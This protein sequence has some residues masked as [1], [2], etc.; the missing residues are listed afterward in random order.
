M[1]VTAREEAASAVPLPLPAQRQC[2]SPGPSTPDAAAEPGSSAQAAQGLSGSTAR[3]AA[4]FAVPTAK[5][6][7]GCPDAPLLLVLGP[8]APASPSQ[9]Q[10]ASASSVSP[11]APTAA[12]AASGRDSPGL[13]VPSTSES[14]AEGGAGQGSRSEPPAL[15]LPRRV[16]ANDPAVRLRVE[17]GLFSGEALVLVQ[18]LASTPRGL[19]QGRS[20]RSWVALQG[21]FKAPVR[22]DSLVTGQ[23][24][25]RPFRR[26]PPAWMVE[27][28]LLGLARKISGGAVM[29]GP[30]SAPSVLMPAMA[31][32]SIIN[33]SRPGSQPPLLEAQEDVRLFAPHLAVAPP[34]GSPGPSRPADAPA[35]KR[36]FSAARHREGL[37]YDT[38]HVWTFHF[39]QQFVDLSAY[40]L[41]FGCATYDL[42]RHLDG[43]PLQFM[44]KDVDSGSYL[45]QVLAWHQRLLTEAAAAAAGAAG[46]AEAGAG[47]GAVVGP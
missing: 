24:F 39:C 10:C 8:G 30:M 7:V 32:A 42:A 2:L 38:R 28:G 44:T 21:R 29:I 5:D 16:S 26:L 37:S 9:T 25:S 14:A 46:A 43:Q 47:A 41:D 15:R 40:R 35:R 4:A 19:F 1:T 11:T 20:R 13:D 22:L 45:F 12:P 36:H 31:A 17:C 34:H 3:A 27:W 33:V 23:E 6:F 18:G